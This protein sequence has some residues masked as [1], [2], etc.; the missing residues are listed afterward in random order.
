MTENINQ[1][2]GLIYEIEGLLL[3]AE[4]KGEDTPTQVWGIIKDKLAIAANLINVDEISCM[5][6]ENAN[7]GHKSEFEP[8]NCD[9]ECL[10]INIEQEL[11][12]NL[13]EFIE[14]NDETDKIVD[15]SIDVDFEEDEN[16]DAIIGEYQEEIYDKIEDIDDLETEIIDYS[17][18]DIID[19]SSNDNSEV[20]IVDVNQDINDSDELNHSCTLD[21][22]LARQGTID[23]KRAFTINDRYRFRRELFGNSDTEFADILNLLS[24]MSSISEAEE[25][26]YMDL[27][28]DKDNE[29]VKDFMSIVSLYF[30]NK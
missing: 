15:E 17:T 27:E 29:E 5:T 30:S 22:K 24:A 11:S 13:S 4:N 10:P 21:E 26:V 18:T 28:W 23:L 7:A 25:Y 16:D 20:E 2:R 12:A 3:L 19:E 8:N 9:E 14:N 1:L 6:V